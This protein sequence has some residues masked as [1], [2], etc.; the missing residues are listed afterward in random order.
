MK[1]LIK[2]ILYFLGYE[3]RKYEKP[4][5]GF[6][7]PLG[8]NTP[9]DPYSKI[10][11]NSVKNIVDLESLATISLTLPGMITPK[12]GQFLYSLCY[13]QQKEGDVVE[14]GSWQGRSSSFLARAVL[15]SQNGKFYTIDHFKG[16]SGQ[17]RS[18]FKI[19][20]DDLN[21]LENNLNSNMKRVG[22]SDAVTLL[23]MPS[24]QAAKTLSNTHIR[25]LFIDGDH[26]K[27]G[28]AKDIQLFFP[29]LSKGSIVVFD[30]F[31][32][33]AKGLLEAIDEQLAKQEVSRIMS[34]AGTLV[35][36]I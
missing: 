36:Q 5:S 15:N 4:S 8:P 18:D 35:F 20:N 11:L 17:D 16:S 10:K 24:E 14:I 3:I 26:T 27:Q 29:M 23:N 6:L 34:Y 19:E 28:V 12:S 7:A 32:A 13:M 2:K 33:H 25:F 30:D 31:R 9:I 22:L 1:N 21:D